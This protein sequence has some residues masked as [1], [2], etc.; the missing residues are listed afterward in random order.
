VTRGGSVV[1]DGNRFRAVVDIGAPGGKRRQK[2]RSVTIADPDDPRS[3]EAAR[4]AAELLLVELRADYATLTVDVK[5]VGQLCA[6]WVEE[7]RQRR[8][9][10]EIEA[11]TFS[12]AE[13][14]VRLHIVPHLGRQPL[15]SFS[16]ADVLAW[17]RR[18]ARLVQD[19]GKPLS[20]AMRAKSL[21]TLKQALRWGL[22]MQLV[23]TNPAEPVDPPRGGGDTGRAASQSEVKRLL[24]HPGAHRWLFTV[25]AGLGLRIGE[26]LGIAWADVDLEER[27]LRVGHQVVRERPQPGGDLQWVRRMPKGR[28]PRAV[29]LPRFVVTAFHEQGVAQAAQRSLRASVGLPWADQWGLVFTA[30]DGGPLHASG[31][32]RTLAAACSD[33]G[34]ERLTPHDLRRSCSSLLAAEGVSTRVRMAILGHTTARLTEDVYTR[35]Y[36]PDVRAAMDALDDAMGR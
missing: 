12:G 5:S 36:D 22:R 21:Q 3:V 9:D 4:R 19:D 23:A 29:P 13:R 25:L 30:S 32:G 7:M 17:Q 2:K 1:R 6:L 26:G 11:S 10:G 28:K 14:V 20:V 18:L 34:I 24:D 35:A 8:I 31:V 15:G 16:P 33:L 27:M